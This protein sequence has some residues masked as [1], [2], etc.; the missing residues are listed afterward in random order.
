MDKDHREAMIFTRAEPLG[1]EDAPTGAAPAEG[2][3]HGPAGRSATL[4]LSGFPERVTTGA[5]LRKMLVQAG[6]GGR[7]EGLVVNHQP[8]SNGYSPHLRA[9]VQARADLGRRR[10][11]S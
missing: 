8:A 3:W 6:G 11:G 5:G 4:R 1:A 7:G 9:G 10:S 2:P